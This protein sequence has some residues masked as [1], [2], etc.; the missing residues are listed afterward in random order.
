M[1]ICSCGLPAHCCQPAVSGGFIYA[2]LRSELNTHPALQACLLRVVLGVSCCYK[3]SPF[4]AHWGKWYCTCFLRPG[5]YLKFTWE[6]GLP[7]SPVDFPSIAAF[8][9]SSTPDCWVCAAAPAF[10]SGLW[11]FFPL[12]PLDAQGYVSFLLLL[13]IIQFL[14]FSL[15]G[16]RLSRGLCWSGPGLSVGV[17]LT[18]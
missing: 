15:G 9:S 7:P 12:P 8:K 10:S 13:L 11:G 3:L 14:F 18:A 17:P 1:A 5:V 6:V 4:Q 16:D 2:D